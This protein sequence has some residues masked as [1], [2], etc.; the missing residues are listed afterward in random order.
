MNYDFDKITDRRGTNSYKWDI[1]RD[2]DIIPLWVAD[3]DFEVAPPIQRAIKR[4][5]EHGV[6][7]YVKVPEEYYEASIHWF[8]N[9]HKWNIKREWMTYTIGV[10]P[11]VSAIIKAF[12]QPG[13][14]VILPTPDY[15][16]FFSSIRNNDC[17]I[18]E[19]ALKRTGNTYTFNYKDI[20]EKAADVKAKLLILCNPHNPTGRVWTADELSMLGNICIK[21]NVKIISDDIHCELVMP[22]H[23]YTPLPSISEALQNQCISCISP[24]KSFNTAG[25]QIAN[26]VTNNPEWLTKIDKAININEV[27]DV[28]PFGVEVL[29]AAYN[30]SGDWI[31][32]LCEYVYG[33]YHLLKNFIE[34]HFPQFQVITLEGTYLAW[35]DIKASGLSSDAF[36]QKL[37]DEAHVWVNSG[38]LYGEK[39]GEGF[40]RINLA[41]QRARL[42][43][44]L[45][46][47][48]KII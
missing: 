17:E 46:R 39:D 40:I 1:A 18:V 33:N 47:I 32:Q 26:I 22:G 29:M 16:C 45:K 27:C 44:A 12:T 8:A 42:E 9:R 5:A 41:T 36:T 21:H 43:E 11:A 23:N 28:N 34:K 3:M 6:Y 13:D 48:Q 37:L 31:D 25:L 19:S 35:I 7:G 38:T 14:K 10:V 20:E 2:S 30:E 4:R 24:S 15:N